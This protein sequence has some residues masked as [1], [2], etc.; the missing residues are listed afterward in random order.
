MNALK[1][2]FVS[3][4]LWAGLATA[5]EPSTVAGTWVGTST[6][7]DRE[8]APACND[9][10]IAF[11]FRNV[12]GQRLLHLDAKKL[13]GG[14]Y[15]TM[16]EIDLVPDAAAG[17]WVHDFETRRGEKARWLFRLA[18]G[19]ML[20]GELRDRPSGALLREVSAKRARTETPPR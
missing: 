20:R 16:F 14:T 15:D 4:L 8:R 11:V 7:V 13:A 17:A 18:A 5:A 1:F 2:P 3:L 10:Q 12:P 19:D 6:C 9:E